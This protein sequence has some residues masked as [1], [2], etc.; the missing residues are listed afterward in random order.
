MESKAL[1]TWVRGVFSIERPCMAM[2]LLSSLSIRNQ[3]F[4]LHALVDHER[5]VLDR[6]ER[7]VRKNQASL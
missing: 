3:G 1:Y 6:V 7:I 5:R 4:C 2:S